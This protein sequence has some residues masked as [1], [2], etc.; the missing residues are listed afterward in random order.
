MYLQKRENNFSSGFFVNINM[1]SPKNISGK[2]KNTS[3]QVDNFVFT[4]LLPNRKSFY[5]FVG[6][7]KKRI[8]QGNTTQEIDNIYFDGTCAVCI[9]RKGRT[10]IFG[11][12][13][14]RYP[15]RNWRKIREF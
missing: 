12:S 13:D 5:V 3:V 15:L 1:N 6:K 2:L 10:F 8:Y 14:A 9:C 4:Q 11:P 7:S